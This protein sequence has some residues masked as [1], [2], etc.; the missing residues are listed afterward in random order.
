M[1]LITYIFNENQKVGK[2]ENGVIF[3]ILNFK[4]V[5]EI[6][7][8]NE[9][10]GLEFSNDSCLLNEVKLLSPIPNPK[11]SII[12]LGKNYKDHAIEMKDKISEEVFIP[13]YPIYFSKMVDQAIGTEEEVLSYFAHSR[14]FDYEVELAV[15]IGKKGKNIGVN[16]AKDYIF[17]YSIG[18]DFCMRELQKDHFQ[19][20]KGKSLD[21][22]TVMGPSIVTADEISYPPALEI[23][24][25]VNDEMRQLSK[26]DNL[27]FNLDYIIS[28][29][30][31]DTTLL[32]GDIIFTGT[33]AGVGMGFT[34][35]KFLRPGDIVKCEI[36]GLGQ[37]I[38]YIK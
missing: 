28:D 19:W 20:M 6:I 8:N 38:N 34:P 2:L 17:G 15:I 16:E 1:K 31:K 12:C 10:K 26:T 25:Y 24:A 36:E 7:E 27:I 5:Q 22:H 32:P 18:N 21:T 3:E 33:P 30:S 4:S 23:K 9:L 11:R 37:L 35:P 29:F 14:T 13:K